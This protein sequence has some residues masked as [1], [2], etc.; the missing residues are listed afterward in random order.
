[1][2]DGK[3]HSLDVQ[4]LTRTGRRFSVVLVGEDSL[5]AN[6]GHL[7]A[8]TGGEIFVAS[9]TD[10]TDVLTSAVGTLRAPSEACKPITGSPEHI[11][12][13]RAGMKLT[14]NWRQAEMP[15]GDEVNSRAIA[16]LAASLALA[17]LDEETAAQ[18]AEAEGLVT[19]LTS[20]VLVDEEGAIQEGV[21]ASR[22]V[23][24]PSPGT[25]MVAQSRSNRA[26]YRLPAYSDEAAHSEEAV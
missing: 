13:R 4:S 20:L 3:S 15:A 19:H 16:A 6:V 14:A 12:V 18:V 11:E 1:M 22:K 23:A 25:T 7:A 8:L 21:P 24:L 5:E 10:L 17:T 9:G 26:P 2:T